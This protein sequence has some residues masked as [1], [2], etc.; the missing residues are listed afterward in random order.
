MEEK[1]PKAKVAVA[2][3]CL[4]EK[5]KQL[6]VKSWIIPKIENRTLTISIDEEALEKEAAFNGCYVEGIAKLASSLKSP[7]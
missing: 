6:N 7:F 3:K 2:L 5:I 1:H 4:T